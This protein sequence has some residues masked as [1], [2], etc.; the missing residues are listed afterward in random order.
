MKQHH[1]ATKSK[2]SNVFKTGFKLQRKGINDISTLAKPQSITK[3]IMTKRLLRNQKYQ[4]QCSI[5]NRSPKY[6]CIHYCSQCQEQDMSLCFVLIIFY[7]HYP[8]GLWAKTN[9][10]WCSNMIT[11]QTQSCHGHVINSALNTY[12][13][14][15]L[16]ESKKMAMISPWWSILLFVFSNTTRNK[17]KQ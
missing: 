6:R 11:G 15:M 12:C 8:V 13:P 1:F 14:Q 7:L 16:G 17:Y 5:W 10:W 2:V 3:I 4:H 9:F